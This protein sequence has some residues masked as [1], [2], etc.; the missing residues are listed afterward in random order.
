[1]CLPPSTVVSADA[2]CALPQFLQDALRR[3][4]SKSADSRLLLAIACALQIHGLSVPR[5]PPCSLRL[6]W[7]LTTAILV[8]VWINLLQHCEQVNSA[9]PAL[10]VPA[11]G[12]ESGQTQASEEILI[13][14]SDR[15]RFVEQTRCRP[16]KYRCLVHCLLRC[17]SSL[18]WLCLPVRSL[19]SSHSRRNGDQLFLSACRALD[20]GGFLLTWA[21]GHASVVPLQ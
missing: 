13:C 11:G 7:W 18:C 3:V 6:R 19:P 2:L 9:S 10:H 15:D 14:Q 12:S 4:P 20:R 1:M 21:R 17:V 5:A 8:A 16:V